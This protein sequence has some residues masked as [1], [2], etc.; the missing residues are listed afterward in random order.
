[1]S[2]EIVVGYNGTAASR[3]AVDWA[4]HEAAARSATLRIISCYAI[5]SAADGIGL[6]AG[7]SVKIATFIAKHF[8][9]EPGAPTAEQRVTRILGM[10][11]N[12]GELK[13]A[14]LDQIEPG[15]VE[16]SVVTARHVLAAAFLIPPCP[17]HAPWPPLLRVPSVHVTCAAAFFVD[18]A[19]FA[20]AAVAAE[21][22]PP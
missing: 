9:M 8:L 11:Q 4:A 22:T 6:N 15:I 2:A 1:M 18:L 3:E 17:E 19:A 5:Q 14:G 7:D 20:A 12:L 10:H 16:V 21:S 13:V